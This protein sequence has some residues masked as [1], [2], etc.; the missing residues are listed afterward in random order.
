MTRKTVA[1][2]GLGAIGKEIA[3][4]LDRGLPGLKLVAVSDVNADR[5]RELT[6]P[7]KEPPKLVP[8]AE[9]TSADIVVEAMPPS[10]FEQ[11]ARPAIEAGCTF[12]PCSV[13]ALLGKPELIGL[14]A[15]TGARIIAPTGA[16][17]G[18]DAIRAICQENVDEIVLK[19]RKPP[20]GFIG[21]SYV[22]S[23][24]IDIG[25]ISEPTMLFR[26]NASDACKHFPAN[27][28]VA[29]ALALAG[30][31][32][33]KTVVEIWAD[34]GVTRNIHAITARSPSVNLSIAVENVPSETNPKTSR[35]APLS[36][37]ACLAGLA[38]TLKV[39][40]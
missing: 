27:A 23:L 11:I 7:Y 39:G 32:P 9:L 5:V 15:K 38:G 28:N 13:G 10:L 19:S 14:A 8:L 17:A 34:P 37:L 24:G 30:V 25:K 4:A 16:I 18:L 26:G 20:V 12:V 22:E 21:V 1:I 35:L 36:I 40:S 3:D 6:Q 2:A 33:A 31:G 29:G